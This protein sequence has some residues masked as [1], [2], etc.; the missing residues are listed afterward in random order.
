M[1]A[2]VLADELG[3]RGRRRV[4]AASAV[5]GAGLVAVVWLVAS[6]LRAEGQ[7]D[8]DLWHPLATASVLR[9][10]AGGLLNTLKAAAVAM[11]AATAVG[12]LMALARLSRSRLVRTL[13]ALYV[14]FFRAVPLIVLISFASLGL[15]RQGI[16][17]PL[18]WYLVI[19]LSIYNSSVLA[20][21]FRAGILSLD[22]GQSEAAHALGLGYW[23]TMGRVVIPQAARRMV[24]AVVSQWVTL[25]KD[26]SLGFVVPYDD[27]LGR[28]KQTGEFFRNPLQSLAAA[29]AVYVVVNFTLSRVARRLEVR[30]RRRYRAGR[31]DVKGV[32]DLA[33]LGAHGEAE[34]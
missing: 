17:L 11:L 34:R 29:A 2:T 19:G 20:E 33:V 10:L 8:G 14:D 1:T 25:L 12:V 22:R 16:S 13:A 21:I 23:S 26:T 30:Q 5:A 7:L 18:F 15:P 27:L 28:A 6:R 32:E 24:P 3:P 9:F 31:I 4:A